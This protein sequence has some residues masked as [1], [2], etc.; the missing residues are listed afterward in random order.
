VPAEIANNAALNACI[1]QLPSNYAFEVAKCVWRVR[2]SGASCVALQMPEGLLAYACLLADIIGTFANVDT[3]IMGDVTY[4]ACCVDD[5]T[6]MALGCD[7]LIHYGHSCLVPI[8]VTQGITVQYVFVDIKFD[9]AH[10]VDSMRLNFAPTQRLALVSTV[11]FAASLHT[12]HA[13]LEDAYAAL[14]IPQAR[15]L[16]GG[17]VLGCTS[18]VLDAAA[19]DAL[20]YIGDGRFHLESAMIANPTLPAFRYDPYDKKFTRET[21][22]YALM[23]RVRKDAVEQAKRARSFGIIHGTLGRQGNPAIVRRLETLLRAKGIPFIV[24]L[25]SEIFPAKLAMFAD[26]DA[27]VQVACPR[28]SID[29]GLHFGKPLL[30]PYEAE[31]VLN[32]AQP[33]CECYPMDFYRKDGGRWTN[34]HA[35]TNDRRR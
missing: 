14:V 35:E 26:I 25:L 11:Q 18:P 28:L 8:Y 30:N 29:W 17:E 15:P 1:A 19:L 33:W 4:G 6:A 10:F 31:V 21:Y 12:A 7:Y 5:A 13:A 24:V 9:L 2:E 22:D 27:W 34:Y 16:S 3:V 23:M 20:V 32:D